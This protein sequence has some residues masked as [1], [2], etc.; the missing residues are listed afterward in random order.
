MTALDGI[1]G[2]IRKIYQ[3]GTEVLFKKGLDFVD[4]AITVGTDRL[5]LVVSGLRGR[6]VS[7]TAPT[8]GQVLGFDGT[9]WT[10]TAAGLADGTAGQFLTYTTS[11]VAT[12]D[13]LLAAG[14]RAIGITPPAS[15]AGYS[16]TLSGSDGAAGGGAGGSAV[17]HAG[18][19][20]VGD[21][22]G[23]V[24]LTIDTA[25]VAKFGTD[26]HGGTGFLYGF[27]GKYATRPVVN[28][29]VGDDAKM[30]ELLEALVAVG[31]IDGEQL[32]A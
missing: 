28:W 21:D 24:I 1:V 10:P 15:G 27:G 18:A 22:D 26:V 17:V 23:N 3:N 20:G 25:V 12:S 29:L 19:G 5:S 13:F 31:V 7:A 11:W 16:L 9:E 14:N 8:T 30:I 6:P 4:M 32:I 2:G